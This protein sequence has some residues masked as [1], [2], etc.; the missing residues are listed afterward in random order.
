MV[1]FDCDVHGVP[2]PQI[3]WHRLHQPGREV[4]EEKSEIV[5]YAFC[6]IHCAARPDVVGFLLH[7]SMPALMHFKSEIISPHFH[8]LWH[9]K[10]L[11]FIQYGHQLLWV[12]IYQIYL[13]DIK[14]F[15]VFQ[16]GSFL[17]SCSGEEEEGLY[18]CTATNSLNEIR[19]TVSLDV[20]GKFHISDRH[21]FTSNWSSIG[22]GRVGE[23]ILRSSWIWFLECKSSMHVRWLLQPSKSRLENW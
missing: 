6:W 20:Q 5:R 16:N 22:C 19:K 10:I 8:C 4:G 14:Y 13:L 17:I 1:M 18:Q 11:L 2:P 7:I 9:I 15:R 12:V 21:K 3:K 23:Q